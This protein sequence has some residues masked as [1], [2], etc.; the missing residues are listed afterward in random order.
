MKPGNDKLSFIV[1]FAYYAL[2]VLLVILAVKYLLTP[3]LPFITAFII[4]SV[5]R[6]L[7]L[8]IEDLC[9]SKKFA[10]GFFTVLLIL[11]LSLIIY[12]IC[13]GLFRELMSLSKTLSGESLDYYLQKVSESAKNIFDRLSGFG[14]KGSALSFL[15]SQSSIENAVTAI[16]SES[17]PKIISLLV[18]FIS[19]FPAAILFVSVMFI[20]MFYISHDYEKICEFL[21]MQMPE[22]LLDT[23]DE[24]K[25]IITSTAH[26]LFK[27]YF[28]LTFITFLQLLTGFLII[29]IDYAIILAVIISLVDL[30][31]ILGTG[32]VLIPW[33]AICFILGDT[34]T[35]IGLAVLYAVIA[36][37]R[38]LAQPKIIGSNV[39]LSPLL[40]L[41]SIFAGLKI[42]GVSGIIIFPIIITTVIRLNS[43]GLLHLYKDFPQK[44]DQDIQK[45]KMKFIN[46]KKNDILH[47]SRSD[48]YDKHSK[49]N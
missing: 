45:T 48:D 24:T 5:S 31:P 40:S 10:S 1:D 14:I 26:E 9:R 34:V 16:M 2:I 32:T 36:I 30:L 22:K 43:K 13:L 42:M 29:G 27:S 39:G 18:K 19:F 3:L 49:D 23:L 41:I 47:S 11:I 28:L 44:N 12:G 6:K 37:F 20:S 15:N 35:S 46:F 33:A 38:Q 4:V 17:I 21:L 7:I 25:N 8:R